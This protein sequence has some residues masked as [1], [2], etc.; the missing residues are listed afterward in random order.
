[1]FFS[2]AYFPGRWE[3]RESFGNGTFRINDR[4]RFE[5][6]YTTDT[7]KPLSVGVQVDFDGGD[8]YGGNLRKW[9]GLTWQPRENLS[10][11]VG[12]SHTDLDGWLL[13]QED[14]NFTTFSGDRWE[15]DLSLDFYPTS[16]QQLRIKLQWVGIDAFEDRFYSLQSDPGRLI[17]GAKPPGTSDDFSISTLN[18]QVRYRWQIAPLSDLFIVYTKGDSRRVAREPLRDLF[19]DSWQD[20][21]A[22]QLVIKLRYRLGS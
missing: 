14:Q 4:G 11:T 5:S 9:G 18:F 8:L 20:P 13:H 21:L 16:A 22:D 12:V 17:E 15:P 7:S 10:M 2:A 3:D 6:S 19:E 1:V